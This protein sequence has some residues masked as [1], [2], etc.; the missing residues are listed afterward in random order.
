MD[1]IE[2][3]TNLIKALNTYRN[4]E[5]EDYE[6]I[7]IVC[8]YFDKIKQE[9]LSEAD[10]SFL[11]YISNII[12]IPHFYDLLE[13]FEQDVT[14]NSFDLNTL[15]AVIYE[16][17]LNISKHNKV[18]KY[19][20]QILELFKP[21]QLNRYFLSASTS[22]GKTHIVFEI[23]KQMD[24]DNVVLI[25][26]TIALLS[27]NL[28]RLTSDESYKFF[29]EKYSIHTLSE[30]ENIDDKN[31]FIYTP[32]R[33]LS[34]VEKR[35]NE[36]EFNFAFIDE[37]YKIDN[38]YIIDEEVRENERDVAY[39]L[40]V[41]YSLKKDVD[42][43]LTGS[44]IDFSRPNDEN[45][46]RSFDRFLE[47]NEIKLIDYNNYEIVNKTYSDIKGKK[48]YEVD[49][50]LDLTFEKKSKNDRL[51]EILNQIFN[52][53]ENTIIYCYSRSSAESYA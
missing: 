52:I 12:G 14:I 43:L 8:S 48:S 9:D 15:S 26:P 42:T 45:Y 20:K 6:F 50:N 19:Q 18:H 34:F 36:I 44:Y 13:K 35:E 22:F 24:Y 27:E 1:R 40:A 28:E 39:R 37:V 11:K 2:E 10:L 17:T 41:F 30:V 21:N 49:Y 32:E 23:I 53:N 33:Y 3:T 16:S 38:D 46:N 47:K 5:L 25:F 31:L 7:K 51:I 29:V 4:D